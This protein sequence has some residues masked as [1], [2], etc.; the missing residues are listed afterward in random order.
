[1]RKFHGECDGPAQQTENTLEKALKSSLQQDLDELPSFAFRLSR[2]N[3]TY[4][5]GLPAGPL[6]IDR[7]WPHKS[8]HFSLLP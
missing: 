5:F 4:S 3:E 1:M 7:Y 2:P 8:G 6:G